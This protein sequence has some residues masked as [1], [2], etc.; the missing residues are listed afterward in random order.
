MNRKPDVIR[1]LVLIFVVG[2]VVSGFTHL[3]ASESS[4][5]VQAAPAVP[6]AQP[7]P[8]NWRSETAQ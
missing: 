4:A 1:S 8:A 2:L 7:E 5:S 6:Q 3:G